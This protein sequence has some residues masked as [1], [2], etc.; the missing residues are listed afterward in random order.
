MMAKF[1]GLFVSTLLIFSQIFS[2][3]LNAHLIK[4][5]PSNL[6]PGSSS[7]MV[8]RLSN[9]NS[10]DVILNANIKAPPTWRLFYNQSI[11]IQ[12]NSTTILPIGVKIPLTTEPGLYQILLE[13]SNSDLN[14]NDTISVDTHVL[15][16]IEIVVQL[17]DA[18]KIS[19]SG[20]DILVEFSIYN[21]SNN[22][23]KIKL[24]SSTSTINGSKSLTLDIGETKIIN[25]FHTTNPDLKRTLNQMIDLSVSSG[26]Y[27]NIEK[28][29]VTVIP[30][31]TYKTDKYHR[32]PTEV[33]TMYLYRKFGDYSYTGFQGNLFI[34]GSLDLENKHYFELRARGP[35]QFDNSILGLYE[36]YYLN[37]SSDNIHLYIGDDTYSLTSLTEYGRFGTG[38]LAEYD[39]KKYDL[40]FFYMQPRF[41]PDYQEELA[42]F[43]NYNFD[44][45]NKVGLNFL[46]KTP[47][48]SK[49]SI[50][51]Y[52]AEYTI[53]PMEYMKMDVEYSFGKLDDEIGTGYS[54]EISNQTEKSFTS[55]QLVDAG[56]N[57]PGYY[58]NTRYLN[59][60]IQYVVNNN[61]KIFSN[62][63]EDES[64]AQRDTL[65]GVSP[66]SK[67]LVGGLAY[68]YRLQD[69]ISLYLG[70]RERKDRMPQQKF[71]Y[72]E[73]FSRI[74]FVN[75]LFKLQTNINGELA[76]TTNLMTDTGGQSYKGSLTLRYKHS[77]KFTYGSFLQYYDTY[78]YSED[79]SQ[80][81]IYGGETS[82]RLPSQTNLNISFQ[83]SHNIEDY[84][85]DRSLFDLRL[86]KILKEKHKFELLWSEALKQKQID[87][88]DTYIGLKYTFNFGIPLKKT[89]NLGSVRGRIINGGIENIANIVLNLGGRIQ[90][91]DE[92]GIFIF[93]DIPPGDHYLYIDDA[94][95]NFNDI[96][97]VK[98]PMIVT[99]EP[100]KLADI[101]I[102]LTKAGNISGSVILN[103]EDERSE[104]L[105]ADESKMDNKNVI[106]ELQLDDE[107]H[108]SIVNLNDTFQ[109]IGL[110][111][112]EWIVKVYHNSLDSN[113]TIKNSEMIVNLK[114]GESTNL[115]INVIKKARR[116]RFHPTEIIVN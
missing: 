20:K 70:K 112:G 39:N 67:Y 109:F 92:D 75:N 78:R 111:P 53:N 76:N 89:K 51:I 72:E 13:L 29:Y 90:L 56:E 69:N 1:S 44:D 84:Y 115:N 34:G 58:N 65:Y 41:S 100:D 23:R 27:Q 14:Y 42:G 55:V 93:V 17:V 80:E 94:S 3:N 36:E 74:S 2:Q 64:N 6:N 57:F 31:K 105:T 114:A 77:S 35:D 97:T 81:I 7:T 18:P 91:T 25:V 32:I 63:H 8:F 11:L 59:G 48:G 40:G 71:H 85:R 103:F 12:G 9:E 68:T 66:Y 38:I 107:Y 16:N 106:V 47:V 96:A 95:L 21:K 10:Q 46:Q 88:R 110:R 43:V 98:T 49:K 33:S 22:M 87:D 60:N 79:R 102:E 83:N 19:M 99:I 116:I 37:Y 61:L 4:G 15:K 104:R 113:F 28:T 73:N 52:S 54:I 101:Q 82:I 5:L 50:N 86:T 26:P 108:R 45:D 62:F 24:E 30:S